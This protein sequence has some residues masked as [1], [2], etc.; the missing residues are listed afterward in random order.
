[1]EEII[2][3]IIAADLSAQDKLRTAAEIAQ[4]ALKQVN[5]DKGRVEEEVWNNAKQFVEN[6]KT[7]LAKQL[8]FARDEHIREYE[9]SLVALEK[10]FASQREAWRNELYQR[11]LSQD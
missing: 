6:E 10:S 1:M 9:S 5:L 7:K 2:S 8:L 4:Q 11:C 3:R